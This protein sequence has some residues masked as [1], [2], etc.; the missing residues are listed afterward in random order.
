MTHHDLDTE[1]YYNQ[2]NA[3]ENAIVHRS[4]AVQAIKMFILSSIICS[5]LLLAGIALWSTPEVIINGVESLK[6][7]GIW[8]N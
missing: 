5:G 7:Q 2:K 8:P 4:E 3:A 1:K 6:A